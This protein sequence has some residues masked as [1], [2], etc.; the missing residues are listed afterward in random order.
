VQ[1]KKFSERR[2]KKLF[3][4][5]FF[6]SSRQPMFV[7]V[8]RQQKQNNAGKRGKRARS[9][10]QLISTPPACTAPVGLAKRREEKMFFGKH[11]PALLP[12]S[13]GGL[14]FLFRRSWV[15]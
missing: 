14:A 5:L 1:K 9:A 10:D 13:S 8:G 15:A 2:K 3:L 12:F 6:P 4:S 11:F 7:L